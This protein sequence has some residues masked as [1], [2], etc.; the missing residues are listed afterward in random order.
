MSNLDSILALV[1][2][3]EALEIRAKEFVKE[4][5]FLRELRNY[6]KINVKIETEWRCHSKATVTQRAFAAAAI[7]QVGE[8]LN[9][10][11]ELAFQA[12]LGMRRL[13]REWKLRAATLRSRAKFMVGDQEQ[14]LY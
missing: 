14:I 4:A 1:R 7:R 2:E 13:A 11:Y 8:R 9:M 10:G 3:A 5:D 6:G 12:E